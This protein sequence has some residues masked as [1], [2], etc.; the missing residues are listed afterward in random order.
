M[1]TTT[2]AAA[3]A[4]QNVPPDWYFSSIKRNLLQRMWH[5][6]RFS[7]VGELV[8][9]KGGRILDIGCADGM[10]T[11]V[12][13]DRSNGDVVGIDVLRSSVAW[14]NKHWKKNNNMHFKVGNAHK[15]EFKDKSFDAVF[16]L[17]VMEHVPEPDMVIKEIKRVLKKDGY[18]VVLVPTDSALFRAIWWFVTNFWWAK[19]WD[20]TH[21]QSFTAS[22]PLSKHMEDAGLKVEVDKKFWL[23]MLNVVKARKTK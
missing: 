4:H 22:N 15:L 2:K 19:I 6:Q 5:K 12:I 9:P 14:A 10:F 16:A 8:E 18:A 7:T 11:K 1:N 3:R 20:E 23:G 17:E 21:V 13:A